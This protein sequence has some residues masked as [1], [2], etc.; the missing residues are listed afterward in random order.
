MPSEMSSGTVTSNVS[1]SLLNLDKSRP[2]GVT[3]KK[4]NGALNIAHNIVACNKIDAFSDPNLGARSHVID[5]KAD[6]KFLKIIFLINYFFGGVFQTRLMDCDFDKVEDE[7]S[8]SINFDTQ[9]FSDCGT[10]Y[11]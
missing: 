6:E 9:N 2:M 8:N 10:F 5:A 7:I 1:I 11:E 3:S 4:I